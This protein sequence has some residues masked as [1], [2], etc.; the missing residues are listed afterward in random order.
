RQLPGSRLCCCRPHASEPDRLVLILLNCVYL[1][2]IGIYF[3]L[4]ESL[5]SSK[6]D[7][8]PLSAYLTRVPFLSE[9]LDQ[10]LAT[11]L[12]TQSLPPSNTSPF[13]PSSLPGKLLEA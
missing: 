13:F 9:T 4:P 5:P 7:R 2:P 1:M 6:R 10:F 3:K 12:C 11:L 8:K